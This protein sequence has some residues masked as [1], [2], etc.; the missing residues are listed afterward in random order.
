MKVEQY[1]MFEQYV[2]LSKLLSCSVGKIQGS[3]PYGHKF[4][5]HGVQNKYVEN[6]IS[7][8]SRLTKYL[9]LDKV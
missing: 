2:C 7:S 6:I 1:V 3:Q 8:R 9:I 5:P 4:E